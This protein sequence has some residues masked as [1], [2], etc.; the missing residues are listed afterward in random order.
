MLKIKQHTGAKAFKNLDSIVHSEDLLY[1]TCQRLPT[2][3]WS[4][5]NSGNKWQSL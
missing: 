4:Q 5:P 1:C 3:G 2:H